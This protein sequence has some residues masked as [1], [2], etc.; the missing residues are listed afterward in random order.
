VAK[1]IERH[2]SRPLG[3]RVDAVIEEMS[4][5]EA[6]DDLTLLAVRGD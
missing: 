4:H 2:A 6:T 3:E 5:L 1:L